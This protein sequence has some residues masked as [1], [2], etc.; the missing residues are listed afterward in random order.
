MESESQGRRKGLRIAFI[1]GAAV[2]GTAAIGFGGLAA[3]S[4]TTQNNGSSFA[5]GTVHH[6]N[7]ASLNGV[8]PLVLCDDTS[9]P[10]SCGIIFNKTNARPGD[11]I[12][13]TVK[14]TNTGSLSSTFTVNLAGAPVAS[15]LAS[16]IC[17]DLT[18]K[19]A[20]GSTTYYNGSL[21]GL[22]ATS[23]NQSAGSATWA[24]TDNNTLTF[25]ATLSAT[26]AASSM[27]GACTTAIL[28]TQTNT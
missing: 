14:I 17:S 8:G 18:L 13:G 12:A 1:V 4:V 20:D 2:L 9:S 24:T 15:P 21:T 26:P 25:T 6:T 19:I 11:T 7:N 23:L 16:A 3:W 10:A 5:A 28:F 22:T 27:G